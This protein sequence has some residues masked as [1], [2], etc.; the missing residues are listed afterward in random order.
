MT[1][2]YGNSCSGKNHDASALGDSELHVSLVALRGLSRHADHGPACT[3]IFKRGVRDYDLN[4]FLHAGLSERLR[5]IRS[6]T[7]QP[8]LSSVTSVMIPSEITQYRQ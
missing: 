5:P 7:T 6:A 3:S 1:I 2:S 8:R 4:Q